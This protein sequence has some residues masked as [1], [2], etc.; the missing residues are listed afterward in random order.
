M[1]EDQDFAVVMARLRAGDEAAARE[2]FGRFAHRLIGLARTRLGERLRPKVDAE[3]VVQSVF[4]SF[5]V[6]FAD[7]RFDLE[8]WDGLW[9][10]L[11]VITLRKCGY[12]TRHFRAGRRDVRRE[13][14]GREDD[15]ASAWEAVARE[16]T[17][18]EAAQLTE[19]VEQLF[20]GLDDR[21]RRIVELSL[22]G[23][24]VAE[25]AAAVGITERTV[26]RTLERVKQR[27]RRLGDDE[28]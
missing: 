4:K 16:P 19:T 8:G 25:T 28:G 7:D 27:L 24:T 15:S 13:A 9:S 12:R 23:S 10:L 5:F 20:A 3:D 22:Q 11:T 18:V 14:A 26:Y 21:N 2:V 6:R 1:A 17:P